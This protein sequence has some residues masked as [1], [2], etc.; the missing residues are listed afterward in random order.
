MAIA[1]FEAEVALELVQAFRGQ[2]QRLPQA[3]DL[4]VAEA[5]GLD[6]AERLTL[7]QLPQQLD[8]GQHELGQP[9]LDVLGISVDP[10]RQSIAELTGRI[11]APRRPDQ[12]LVAHTSSSPTNE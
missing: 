7:H 4:L 11:S 2:H 3:F 10:A 5:A 8:D 6:T 12:R 9:A 1:V